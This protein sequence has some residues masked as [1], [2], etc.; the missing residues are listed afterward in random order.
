[1]EKA[2]ALLSGGLD[3]SVAL[4]MASD[5]HE[6]AC[7]LTFD[8]GQ[9]AARREIDSAT[10]LCT[11]LSIR[12]Q[13]IEL[14]WLAEITGTALVDTQEDIPLTEERQLD[15]MA[16]ASERARRVWVP[17]RNGVMV[18]I[19]AC[20]ADA[21]NYNI[22]V[23]G[24]N[25]EEGQSFIDNTPECAAA[26][27]KALAYSTLNAPRVV[28]PV[29]AMTKREIAAEAHKRGLLSFWSCYYGGPRM[30]GRCESCVRTIRAF[31]DA[32]HIED[33]ASIFQEQGVVR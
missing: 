24:F 27:T 15:E 11:K 4:S 1:M 19:A 12:H 13:V 33:I 29:V 32:G 17:N 30:C 20:F 7:A 10:A 9:R 22:I 31:R 25:A 2:I 14:P 28:S 18:N 21:Q 3:S 5:V 6:I 23:V 26:L 8:Y 16:A